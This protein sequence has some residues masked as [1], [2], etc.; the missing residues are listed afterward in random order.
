MLM[1][2]SRAPDGVVPPI[3][4]SIQKMEDSLQGDAK[5]LQMLSTSLKPT[6]PVRPGYGTRGDPVVLWANYVQMT[7]LPTLCLYRYSV[8]VTPPAIGRKLTQVVR[9]LLEADELID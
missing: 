1:A 3:D 6:Y 5:T 2:V 7:P 4:A 9:L 8:S